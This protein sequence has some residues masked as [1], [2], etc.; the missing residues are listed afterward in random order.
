MIN[1]IILG[2]ELLIFLWVMSWAFTSQFMK[3]YALLQLEKNKNTGRALQWE[4]F[5]FLGC[6]AIL[7]YV[8][9]RLLFSPAVFA[10]QS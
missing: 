5:T 3:I 2:F 10:L 4:I 9:Q 8:L 1:Y 6:F 7:F